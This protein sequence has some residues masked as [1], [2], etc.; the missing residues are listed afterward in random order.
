MDTPGSGEAP[1]D[2]AGVHAQ[3]VTHD[4]KGVPC[5]G[6][7]LAS[8]GF[9]GAKLRWRRGSQLRPSGLKT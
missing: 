4:G 9:F 1:T 8:G 2:R 6:E 3:H 7:T 5:P